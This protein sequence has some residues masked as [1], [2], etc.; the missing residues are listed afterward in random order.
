[1]KKVLFTLIFAT[2]FSMAQAKVGDVNQDGEVTA[3]DI[4]A[5]YNYILYGD[6]T[7]LSTSDTNNDGAVTSSD[8]TFIYNILLY[9]ESVDQEKA[10]GIFR[11]CYA[12]M[13]TEGR[14]GADSGSDISNMD[15]G[16]SSFYRQMWNSNELTT[17]E[18]ICG[19]GDYGIYDYDFN[20]YTENH[21][22][23]KG[24]FLRLY[25]SIFL[26]NTYL[27][28]CADLDL[29]KTAEVRF[30]RAMYYYFAMDAFGNIPYYTQTANS[31]NSYDITSGDGLIYPIW[32]MATLQFNSQKT[33]TEMFSFIE[34]ELIQA[35]KNMANPA[36]KNSSDE[37]YWRAD[38]A[39]AWLMLSRLYLNAE[40]Y[41]G[42]SQWSKARDY[43]K[44]VMDSNY[45]LF[46]T[47]YSGYGID[48]TNRTFSAYQMLFM[49]DNGETD[50]SKE[51]ILI[52]PH[53]GNNTFY[54]SWNNSTFLICS[55]Y[56]SDMHP[57]PYDSYGTNGIYQYSTWAGNRA[58]PNLI[59][60]FFSSTEA[61][62]GHA[63]NVVAAAGDDRAIFETEGRIFNVNDVS[64]FKN[65]YAVAKFNNYKTNGAN[66]SDTRF[67]D[68]DVFLLRKAEAYL[69]YAEALTRLNG[70]S[71]APAEA[72]D[73]INA[74][75]GR[76]HAT[77]KSS[78]SLNDILDEWSREFYF[79]GR[80]RV[81]L[82]R[83]GKYGGT[84][85]YQWQWKGSSYAGRD[86]S[87][88]RN[89]FA[90]PQDVIATNSNIIQ[91]EGYNTLGHDVVIDSDINISIANGQ[92]NKTIFTSSNISA[93]LTE[94]PDLVGKILISPDN[95]FSN[96]YS[97]DCIFNSAM[98]TLIAQVDNYDLSNWV[99]N[100]SPDPSENLTL[101]AKIECGGYKGGEDYYKLVNNNSFA[102]W[103]FQIITPVE[104]ELWYM[105]G[106]C[107][108]SNDWENSSSAIGT[109]LIPL[110]PKPG[111]VNGTLV[112]AGYFP[113]GG[114]FK[115]IKYP[116][117]WGEQMN[118]TNI[119]SNLA[120]VT[121]EDGSNHNIG[122]PEDGYYYIEMNTL[123]Y[124]ITFERLQGTFPEYSTITMPGDYQGWDATGNAMT[125]MGKRD[126]TETHDWYSNMGFD[127]D[128]QLKFANGSWDMNWG[129]S[130]F[131]FGYGV[132]DGDNIPVKEGNYRV[133][134]NDILGLYYFQNAQ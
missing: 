57:N 122:I 74:I 54:T 15:G 11:R 111:S 79:E 98:N 9:G 114:Q 108:G 134:F 109:G 116:G 99:I 7:Y 61:P 92:N 117:D 55:T 81:D 130:D 46:T 38:K 6:E 21:P 14:N 22:M 26:C 96:C 78:Y 126:N 72:V 36:P 16:F 49:G 94:I 8:I 105:V 82:I 51:A 35:E 65:G 47:G 13:S 119:I 70:G 33:R 48:G 50:A 44:K 129:G 60:K 30:L 121:D 62:S 95:T 118:F 1:M 37:M 34:S 53:N 29:Q 115:F 101:Y 68:M 41:T 106:N 5:I 131:P 80:R 113:A 110:L 76:A 97:V 19:W 69:T 18:A 120:G 42:T 40:V 4:T 102:Q 88:F 104:I 63:Y 73:A 23:L 127:T 128:A 77:Q 12:T 31:S 100:N 71:N 75:R 112:Y 103:Q 83:F 93:L 66:G 32:N 133:Y 28:K 64:H 90:I 124:S 87:S 20:F 107:V 84:T 52:I 91:N 27:E 10:E 25:Y 85:D 58:R 43:A 59:N 56:D 67:P 3:S 86:F 125:P 24:Y 89:V 132:Q 123:N 2:L 39:A 45:Q 17:D